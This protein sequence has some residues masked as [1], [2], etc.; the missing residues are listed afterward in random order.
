MEAY[1]AIKLSRIKTA[2]RKDPVQCGE[3]QDAIVDYIFS[4]V[5]FED[6][7][8]TSS[9]L[10]ERRWLSGWHRDGAS[11]VPLLIA[12]DYDDWSP[13]NPISPIEALAME[14]E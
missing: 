3:G 6:R 1:A 4:L 9:I 14:A 11:L 2:W 12:M 8:V 5:T 7:V 10:E 13:I